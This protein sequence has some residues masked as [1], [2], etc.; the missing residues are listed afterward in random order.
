[1]ASLKQQ[2]AEMLEIL[3]ISTE[4]NVRYSMASPYDG[5]IE[6][7]D[8]PFAE[9]VS[10]L[11]RLALEG[12]LKFTWRNTLF[13]P[14]LTHISIINIARASLPT[15]DELLGCLSRCPLKEL[16]LRNCFP[17]SS[18][19]VTAPS[20][21]KHR[22][23]NLAA[24]QLLAVEGNPVEIADLLRRVRLP[25]SC[26]VGLIDRY[27]WRDR[28]TSVMLESLDV[29]IDSVLA[30]P[31][32][33]REPRLQYGQT[34]RPECHWSLTDE[35]SSPPKNGD[36][37][38]R[39]PF[40]LSLDILPVS[41]TSNIIRAMGIFATA[42]LQV[43]RLYPLHSL[44]TLSICT[45]STLVASEDAWIVILR[46]LQR[47]EGLDVEGACCYTF[48]SAF[49]NISE[50]AQALPRLKRLAVTHAHLS[51]PLGRAGLAMKLESALVKR[52]A[53]GASALSLELEYCHVSLAQL[54]KLERAL[55]GHVEVKGSPDAWGIGE[56]EDE[57]SVDESDS[58][59]SE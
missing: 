11:R 33:L 44:T 18:A 26:S 9:P 23:V 58:A 14:D 38:M 31:H 57:T 40:S 17:A 10:R 30:S 43:T 27:V 59:V 13:H 24:L 2:T 46:E 15:M 50:D 1:M 35:S 55:G 4:P 28:P 56:D 52:K 8:E 20:A 32:A 49:S 51:Y 54:E 34:D 39:G 7:P 21:D 36:E 48:A 19:S 16:V 41:T 53:I 42:F 37:E 12:D 47:V 6:I 3:Q 5:D 45:T 22:S 25:A 29:Q